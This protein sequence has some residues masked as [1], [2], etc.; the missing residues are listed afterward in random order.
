MIRKNG[1][2]EKC[3]LYCCFGNVVDCYFSSTYCTALMNV[4]GIFDAICCL[5]LSCCETM[6]FI[7]SYHISFKAVMPFGSLRVTVCKLGQE[8]IQE[9]NRVLSF[10]LRYRYMLNCS[11][12]I[13]PVCI[14]FSFP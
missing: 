8:D 5:S 14:L 1:D 12:G 9:M 10:R 11:S 6:T 7:T 13:Y 3:F 2:D 4:H